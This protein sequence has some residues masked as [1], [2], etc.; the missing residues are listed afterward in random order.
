MDNSSQ[1]DMTSLL[2]YVKKQGISVRQSGF[3]T[4][5]QLNSHGEVLRQFVL[6][7][8]ECTYYLF[9]DADVCF[10]EDNTIDD[11]VTQLEKQENVFGA[12]VRQTWDGTDEIPEEMQ[13]EIYMSRLHPCCALVRNTPLFRQ[14]AEEL[15][16]TG[17]KYCWAEGEQ[18]LD[19]FELMTKVMKT[20]GFH[21]VISPKMVYHFFS[22]SYDNQWLESKNQRC[23]ALLE[24][25]RTQQ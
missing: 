18:Y 25:L 10:L 16:F 13:Q 21:H 12:G 9:L 19:T 15:G 6:E 24:T 14:I 23:D 2:A 22:V 1:D 11:M 20:H 8:S 17:V 4:D 7:N 5:T 3:T